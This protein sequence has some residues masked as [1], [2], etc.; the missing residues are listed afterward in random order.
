MKIH[1]LRQTIYAAALTAL[2]SATPASAQQWPLA[3]GD[4]WEVSEIDVKDGGDFAYAQHL[5]TKWKE[6]EEFAKSKGWIKDYKILYNYHP[7]AGEPDIYLISIMSKLP[8]G[9]ENDAR[10]EAFEA[11]SKSTAKQLSEESGNRAQFRTLMG[12]M[13]LEE[14][15][16]K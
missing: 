1:I 10:S 12:T 16:V 11:W 14:M 3:S 6:S 13:L 9:P 7:R 4:Y 5:A 8:T 15:K 2:V